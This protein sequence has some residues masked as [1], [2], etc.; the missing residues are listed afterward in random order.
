MLSV[1]VMV[2]SRVG[3]GVVGVVDELEFVGVFGMF[4]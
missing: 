2:V 3:E 4:R 1:V